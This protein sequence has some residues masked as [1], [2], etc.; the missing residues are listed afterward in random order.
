MLTTAELTRPPRAARPPLAA[1]LDQ[2]RLRRQARA[3]RA[4]RMF[5]LLAETFRALGDTSRVELIWC[6]SQGELC[7]GDLAQLLGISQ[8]AVSHHLR[9]LRNLK[10]VRVRKA[11]RVSFYALDDEHI[12]RL[13]RE[14]IKHVEDLLP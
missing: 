14:G 1:S 7:V 13:L 12:D 3:M 5:A 10:L 9:T 6:L 8:P 11:G 2:T 4:R